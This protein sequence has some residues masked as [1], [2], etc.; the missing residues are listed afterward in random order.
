V[1]GTTVGQ[2]RITGLIGRGGMGAVYRAEHTLL[3]RPAAIKLLLPELSRDQDMVTR[4]FNEARA[5]A[6]IRHPGIVEIVVDAPCAVPSSGPHQVTLRPGRDRAMDPPVVRRGRNLRA[7]LGLAAAAAIA[8][9]VLQLGHGR[10]EPTGPLGR[11]PSPT[12]SLATALP[13]SLP[14]A[15]LATALPVLSPAAIA[16]VLTAPADDDGRS[17]GPISASQLVDPRTSDARMTAS[18]PAPLH[19]ARPPLFPPLPPLVPPPPGPIEETPARPSS[20]ITAA[21][22]AQLYMAVGEQLRQLA[23]AHGA[24]ASE[25]LWTAFRCIRIIDALTDPAKR[26]DTDARLHNLQDQIARASG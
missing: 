1:W 26:V 18:R 21:S 11:P 22:V 17:N 12:A 2:Y 16:P 3:Q 20:T 24:R 14:A 8:V 13:V 23:E 4:F 10:S 5:S 6:A 25:S 7:V 9:S 19:P 15:S